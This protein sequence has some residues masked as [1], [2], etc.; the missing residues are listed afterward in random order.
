MKYPLSEKYSTPEL[1]SKIMGPNPMKLEEELMKRGIFIEL[2]TGNILM[3]MT[4]IGNQ[5]SDYEKL[6]AALKEIAGERIL[7]S[8]KKKQPEAVTRSLAMKPVPVKKEK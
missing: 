5:R 1:Q 6:I 2:V 4:G 7:G 3:C 8:E